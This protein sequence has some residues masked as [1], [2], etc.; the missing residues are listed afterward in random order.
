MKVVVCIGSSCHLKG[1]KFV[2]ERIQELVAEKD[3]G[4]KVEI[5]GM[6]CAGRCQ[7]DVCVMI[8]E[9]AYSVTP[10]TVDEFFENEILAK[11]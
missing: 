11:L 4:D 9:E 2:V 10:A 5:G 6:F 8:G 1:S 3:L 7:K